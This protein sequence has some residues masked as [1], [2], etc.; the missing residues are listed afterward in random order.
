MRPIRPLLA[1]ALTA[2][3]LLGQ[4]ASGTTT[5]PLRP[6]QWGLTQVHAPDAW[7]T[8][9]GRNV[10]V[11]VVDTGVDLGH[12]DLRG[13]LVPGIT[14]VG[15][16]AQRAFCGDGSW[17]G[18][19]GK[20]DESDTHGTHVAGIVAAAAGN[21][22]GI[23]G[24]APGARIMPVKAFDKGVATA[25]SV[26]N[27]IRWAVD[28]GAQV[29]NLSLSFADELPVVGV[30]QSLPDDTT[31]ADEV[32]YAT[33]HGVVVVGSAGN[34]KNPYCEAP[35]SQPGAL[36]VAATDSNE[37]RVPYSDLPLKQGLDALSAPGGVPGGA[38]PDCPITYANTP[39][40]EVISTVPRG[41]GGTSA[42]ECGKDKGYDGYAGTSM[43]APH[44]AGVAAL[45]VAQ[46]RSRDNVVEALEKTA[47]QPV[48]GLTGTY[49]PD[50]G[51]GIVDAAAAVRYPGAG[52]GTCPRARQ[53]R[54][55]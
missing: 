31:L 50:L 20:A 36:C 14:T 33:S 10:V 3:A 6:L 49:T 2:L 44:V 9:T 46:C 37:R 21:G 13:H 26:G 45:L 29:I 30:S 35:A 53:R 18:L 34:D 16:P 38:C 54:S 47:R 55:R 52:S 19:D 5:D 23:A 48:V 28:H 32:A 1:A 24:V 40:R 43:A 8:S 4:G 42:P 22:V 15:C 17:V 11:A 12:P 27:G 25:A 51:Y 39:C 41:F 7:G